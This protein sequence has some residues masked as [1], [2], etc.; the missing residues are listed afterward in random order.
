[1]PGRRVGDL[2]DVGVV[3]VTGEEHDR[4]RRAAPVAPG[5]V[6]DDVEHRLEAVVEG[7]P[8][9]EVE[10]LTGLLG[11]RGDDAAVGSLGR[12]LVDGLEVVQSRW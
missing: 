5:D 9:L 10:Q 7:R 8:V 2:R 11:H 6:H 4:L 1:M 12:R 3:H